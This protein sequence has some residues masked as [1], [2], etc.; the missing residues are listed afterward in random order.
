M[1]TPKKTDEKTTDRTAD[2]RR[3]A[4]ARLS[5]QLERLQKLSARDTHHLVQELGTHQIELEMQNEELRKAQ[6]EI[7][8]S[9]NRYADLYDFAPV[10]YLIFDKSGV[11]RE[12]NLTAAT[13]LG[14]ERRSLANKPFS[15]F[16]HKDDSDA[17]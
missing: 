1:K 14:M 11:I 16:V 9:R 4:E 6:E 2:L 3:Q 15:S 7:E 17:F 12:I 8:E 10:G 13:L 5:T